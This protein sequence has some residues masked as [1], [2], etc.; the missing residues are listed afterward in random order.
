MSTPWGW[1]TSIDLKNCDPELIRSD[2]SIKCFVIELCK[3]IKMERYGE[4]HV[5]HFGESEEV[6]G[7]SMFQLIETS[8]ISAHFVNKTNDIYL[9]IFS[10]KEYDPSDAGHFAELWFGAE[11]YTMNTLE[12]QA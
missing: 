12:R 2:A 3:L 4:C 11:S 7:Y 9:D 5:V 6:A 8:N 10:C 1:S